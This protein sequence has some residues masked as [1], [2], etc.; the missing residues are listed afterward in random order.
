MTESSFNHASE[1]EQ[2]P[3]LYRQ[4]PTEQDSRMK[5]CILLFEI[6]QSE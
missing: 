3:K 6:V 4:V 1:S 2:S 5:L